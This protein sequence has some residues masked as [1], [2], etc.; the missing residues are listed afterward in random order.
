MGY[1]G[2]CFPKDIRALISV[3]ENVDAEPLV[4]KA[5]DSVNNRQ[6]KLLSQIMSNYFSKKGG[7][8]GKTIGVWGLAFKP[9]TDDMREAPS[10]TLIE[11]LVRRGAKLRV[12]DPV[13]VPNAKKILG[14]NPNIS[15]CSSEFDAASGADAIALFTEWKQNRLG[16]IVSTL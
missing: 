6:K 2:S 13:A 10:L 4:L 16:E 15:W 5:A 9:D 1:G 8:K 7:I 12:F 11:D 14:N 3:A